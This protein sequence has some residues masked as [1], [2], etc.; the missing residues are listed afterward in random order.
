[1]FGFSCLDVHPCQGSLLFSW[2]TWP[3]GGEVPSGPPA[4]DNTVVVT[5]DLDSSKRARLENSVDEELHGN[6]LSPPNLPPIL[7]PSGQ[8][9]SG[10]P[11]V[12]NNDAEASC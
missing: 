11:S 7:I 9:L 12:A 10:T 3:G 8:E 5:V 2:S 4:F 6:G 1:M